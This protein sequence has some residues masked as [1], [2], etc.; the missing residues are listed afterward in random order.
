MISEEVGDANE[1][2]T[3]NPFDLRRSA[4]GSVA[5]GALVSSACTPL[6]IGADFDGALRRSACA[7]G[8]F[9]FTYS[10]S[11][12]TVGQI[13]HN[14]FCEKSFQS[15]LYSTG[16]M[17]RFYEDLVLCSKIFDPY[18]ELK[19]IGLPMK[20]FYIEE[21]PPEVR[22]ES[23][24]KQIRRQLREVIR[25]L[26]EH[27]SLPTY[28]LALRVMKH[29]SRIHKSTFEDFEGAALADFV[30][31]SRGDL[32]GSGL[33][34]ELMK[35]LFGSSRQTIPVLF[36]ILRKRL[37]KSDNSENRAFQVR[38]ESFRKNLSE[39]LKRENGVL[40]SLSSPTTPRFQNYSLFS[41]KNVVYTSLWSALAL[42]T[43][44]CPVGF[45]GCLP[46]GIQISG[47]HGSE[48]T[49]LNV[50][51]MVT[52]RFGGWQQPRLTA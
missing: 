17:V 18:S 16:S 32:G 6:A 25:V 45:D 39:L 38:L 19:K 23:P 21:F 28:R 8:V 50:A 9:A 7:N 34:V 13:F 30:A 12:H 52:K 5:L 20:V 29:A 35:A 2:S 14:G 24:S 10:N 43:L 41:E 42:P 44:Q 36:S 48:E 51:R 11:L 22:C 26:E 37:L 47:A 31:K 46:M 15:E 3:K 1:G 49:I 33:Y 27:H 40:I 4:G